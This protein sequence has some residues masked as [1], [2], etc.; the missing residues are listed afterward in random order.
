VFD[1]WVKGLT[2]TYIGVFIRLMIV[3]FCIFLINVIPAAW[4]GIIKAGG[5]SDRT[6]VNAMVVILLIFGVFIF[7]KE[8]PKLITQMFG[9]SEGDMSMGI[10]KKLAGAAVVGGLVAKGQAA[11]KKYAGKAYGGLTGALGGGWDS[12]MNGEGFGAGFRAGGLGG[13]DAGGRQFGKQ[14][15]ESYKSRT[16]DYKGKPGLWGGKSFGTKYRGA[17]SKARD[18]AFAVGSRAR[19]DAVDYNNGAKYAALEH[20]IQQELVADAFHKRSSDPSSDFAYMTDD[21]IM[22]TMSKQASSDASALIKN[23]ASENALERAGARK[24]VEAH[25]ASEGKVF[26]QGEMDSLVAVANKQIAEGKNA[27]ELEKRKAE[28]DMRGVIEGLMK[29]VEAPK[30]EAPKTEPPK[31]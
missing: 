22:S 5:G 6:I 9:I 10:G 28:K 3:Y 14:R 24:A 4:D 25:Y 19:I 21:E 18:D 16:G 29:G 1:N 26:D 23:L 30:A 27:S 7:M 11:G 2:G 13:W 12:M 8:A 31:K 20:A 15:L 17:T